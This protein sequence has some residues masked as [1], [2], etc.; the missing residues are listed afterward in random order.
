MSKAET[1]TSVPLLD[2]DAQF[3]ALEPE[4]KEAVNRVFEHKRFIM[5]P[6]VAELEEQIAEYTG[7]KHAIGCASGSDALLLSLMAINIQPGD[8]VLTT[9]F[10][11]FA[12]AGA[13]S[14]L[15]G[16]PI[17]LDI[18]PVTY[19]LDPN[20]VEDF[21][22]GNHFLARRLNARTERIKAMIPVHLYGQM[23]DMDPL[24]ELA[25]K[26]ELH[27][28]EDA[29]QAIG[30]KYKG[31]NAGTIGTFGCFSFFP[32]K[33]LG[34][35]GDGGLITS[36]DDELADK[37]K[38]LRVHGSRPKYYHKMVGVNSRLD[39]MQAAILQQKLP[40][41]DDWSD[42]RRERALRYNKLF[43]E[44]GVTVEPSLIPCMDNCEALGAEH[45]GIHNHPDKLVVPHE[46]EGHPEQGGRHIY[47]QYMI[48]TSRRDE[49]QKYLKEHGI[50]NAL[51]YPVPLHEQDCF[52]HLGYKPEDC[53]ASHCASKQTIALPVF[54]EMTDAQQD[55]VVDHIVSFL[56]K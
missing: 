7:A 45:C 39:T 3:D 18:D 1:I 27:V 32:S 21:L 5:G 46:V 8:M 55:Y 28:I 44:T 25:E 54:P 48:R 43:K 31:K 9:P 10:T 4:I 34:A 52:G 11:F 12:T 49:L 20:Q 35:F 6:E 15:G 13:I 30:S 29:A 36:N 22:S 56:S 24:M 42:K 47:H 41:L 14:R 37:V 50:G 16:V 26:Y 40:H 2:L 23:A 51:Y 33:N 38:M 53:P 19:N 17:F